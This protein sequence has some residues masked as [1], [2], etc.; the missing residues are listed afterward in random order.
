MSVLIAFSTVAN[1]ADAARLARTLVDEGLA[2][3]V[4][5]IPQ[6]T[7][8]YRW[9][10]E[11]CEESEVLLVIK[12]TRERFEALK[13]R[14]VELHAYEIPELVA[15]AVTDGLAPYLAWLTAATQAR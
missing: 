4:N 9:K 13:E 10:G 15:V 14:V 7:S 3:C 8:T 11:V 1:E 5:R 12:T 2:A 6:I